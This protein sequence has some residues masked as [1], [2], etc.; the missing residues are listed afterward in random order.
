MGEFP[1]RQRILYEG[2]T[3][4]HRKDPTKFLRVNKWA[5]RVTKVRVGTDGQLVE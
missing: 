2:D 5:Y 1:L 3:F 4:Y